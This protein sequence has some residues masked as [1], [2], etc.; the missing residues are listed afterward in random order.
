V[1]EFFNLVSRLEHPPKQIFVRDL[2]RAF[3]HRGVVGAGSSIEEVADYLRATVREAGVERVVTVGN[4]AGG[5]AA[6]L[7]GHL[8]GATEVHAFGPETFLTRFRRALHRDRRFR[9]FLGPL[10]AAGDLDSRYSDLRKVLGR[11]QGDTRFVIHYSSLH[12]LDVAHAKHVR[13]LPGVEL[14]PHGHIKGV[15]VRVLR[16]TGALEALIKDA[17]SGRA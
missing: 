13:N 17:V 1:F 12:R 14:Q 2:E 16:D 6:L 9:Q 11:H 15:F 5:Y 8:I 4:S 3:Y 10:R 7:F